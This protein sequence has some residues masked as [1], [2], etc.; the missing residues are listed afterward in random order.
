M[1]TLFNKLGIDWYVTFDDYLVIKIGRT[2][3]L[4]PLWKINVEDMLQ[5]LNLKP[6]KVFKL[7]TGAVVKHYR[8]GRIKVQPRANRQS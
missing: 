7:K 1:K 2:V 5:R 8:N 6:Y 3:K 4:I